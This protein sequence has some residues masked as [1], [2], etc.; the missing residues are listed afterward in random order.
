MCINEFQTCRTIQ[1]QIQTEHNVYWIRV[2]AIRFIACSCFYVLLSTQDPND[3]N[4]DN[5]NNDNET[6]AKAKL[7]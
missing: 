7:R 3:D 4:D 6:G 5:N 2:I 1:E